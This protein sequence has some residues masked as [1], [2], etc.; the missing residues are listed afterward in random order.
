[1]F[2]GRT[3][4][5]LVARQGGQG[6]GLCRLGGAHSL[7]VGVSTSGW[8]PVSAVFGSVVHGGCVRTRCGGLIYVYVLWGLYAVRGS[9]GV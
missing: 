3:G 9:S 5:G 7:S 8:P 4:A 1:M 6:Y 2:S